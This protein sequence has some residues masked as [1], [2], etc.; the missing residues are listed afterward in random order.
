MAPMLQTL[1]NLKL[2]K[3][4]PPPKLMAPKASALAR[5]LTKMAQPPI[6]LLQKPMAPPPPLMATTK[7]LLSPPQ[8][9]AQAA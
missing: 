1:T 9:A 7:L 2:P 3:L 8:L 4:L 6:P 5:N